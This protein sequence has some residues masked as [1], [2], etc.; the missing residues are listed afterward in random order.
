MCARTC[1]R[2]SLWEQT[3]ALLNDAQDKILDL[4]YTAY[5]HLEW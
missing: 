4:D 5:Q 3:L 2:M 1:K